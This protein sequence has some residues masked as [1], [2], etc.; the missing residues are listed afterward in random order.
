MVKVPEVGSSCGKDERQA[1]DYCD[2]A[3]RGN[4]GT[5]PM[6]LLWPTASCCY[7]NNICVI[8]NSV[9]YPHISTYIDIPS[10][11][12]GRQN[13]NEYVAILCV[14]C[15]APVWVTKVDVLC[16]G[17]AA[18]VSW[19]PIFRSETQVGGCSQQLWSLVGGQA[20]CES[21]SASASK[22]GQAN[23]RLQWTRVIVGALLPGEFPWFIIWALCFE[24]GNCPGLQWTDMPNHESE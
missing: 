14:I 9:L 12:T 3:A 13:I 10:L 15:L 8:S 23:L 18:W 11:C 16:V 20:S 6:S 4:R 19:E 22:A 7:W 17:L 5:C 2:F 21:L 24:L 1:K